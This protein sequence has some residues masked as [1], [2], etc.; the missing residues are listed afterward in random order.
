MATGDELRKSFASD[1]AAYALGVA[2]RQVSSAD[3]DA[4]ASVITE[5]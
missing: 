3:A 1:G 2:T 4:L 5:K